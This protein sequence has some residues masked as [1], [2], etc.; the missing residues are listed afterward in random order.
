MTDVY[1]DIK[2]HCIARLHDYIKN[3]NNEMVIELIHT[4]TY[5]NKSIKT[6]NKATNDALMASVR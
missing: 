6:F 5:T 1:S 2:Y 4:Y 3:N